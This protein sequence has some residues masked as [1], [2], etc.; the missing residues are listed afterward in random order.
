[1]KITVWLSGLLALLVFGWY[2]VA[3]RITPYTS[4]ARVK[5]IVTDIVP[6]VSGYVAAIAVNNAQLVEAGDLL[7]RIDQRPFQLQVDQAR[8]A[9][10]TATQ[11]VGASSSEVEIS[12]ANVSQAAIVLE[13]ARVQ[14]DRIVQLEAKGVVAAAYG[15]DA[16][17][18]LA[19]A[20][21]QMAAAEA[22]LER[23]K[24]QLGTEGA[25]NAQIRNAVAALGQA[26]LALEWTELRA[27]ER[28]V[29]IDLD[30][31]KGTFATAGKSLMTFASLDEVWVEA[32]MTENNIANISIGDPAEITL[33][34]YPGRIFEGVVSSITMGV[35]AGSEAGDLPKPPKSTG[36]MRDPQRF[37]V[38]ISMTGYEVGNEA[39]DIRRML[40]GQADVTVYTGESGVLNSLGELWIRF[41]SWLS[42]AY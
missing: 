41:M 26:Q 15:D 20:E 34:L 8:A 17:A 28:G 12:Q 18:A 13:N 35:S 7:A 36:W 27:P 14:S 22:D 30:I 21:S 29:I 6:E 42:Y 2:L 11:N 1:M 39:A 25:D 9:L 5:T 10:E 23:A 40:N 24:R 38:R 32:Y 3:D 31:G 33:D 37:P 4:N 16:R 19:A